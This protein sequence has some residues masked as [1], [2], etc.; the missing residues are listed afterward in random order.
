MHLV[1]VDFP[2]RVAWRSPQVGATLGTLGD[3]TG[4]QDMGDALVLGAA[5][6]GCGAIGVLLSW[7]MED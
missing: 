4:D 1:P 7:V 5:L 3:L 2:C 6:V